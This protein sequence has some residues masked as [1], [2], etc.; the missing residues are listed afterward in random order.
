MCCTFNTCMYTKQQEPQCLKRNLGV[1]CIRSICFFWIYSVPRLDRATNSYRKV[2]ADRIIMV[3]VT[4]T[5][6]HSQTPAGVPE[7]TLK[8]RHKLFA[9]KSRSQR[10]HCLLKALNGKYMV[11]KAAQMLHMALADLLVT[12]GSLHWDASQISIIKTSGLN[13][14]RLEAFAI[15][16]TPQIFKN[17]GIR[18]C[19]QRVQLPVPQF[20][21]CFLTEMPL[22]SPL[23]MLKMQKWF[24][25]HQL[26][27]IL[28]S[29][30]WFTLL[31]DWVL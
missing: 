29:F 7:P 1:K 10:L 23:L 22:K 4:D 19:C 13:S 26:T 28:T 6:V 17:K 18:F 12:W 20:W 31:L 24:H 14:T 27:E 16:Y 11:G 2:A 9:L 15:W 25:N 8:I 5:L 3:V 30:A 21:V